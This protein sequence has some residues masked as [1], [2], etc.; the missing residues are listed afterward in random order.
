MTT[1]CTST[2][3]GLVGTVPRLDVGPASRRGV[4]RRPRAAPMLCVGTS[5]MREACARGVAR[6]PGALHQPRDALGRADLQHALDR[7]EVHAQVEARR[8][9]HG[10][11]ASPCFRPGLDPLAHRHGPSEP[12]CSAMRPA[13]SGR[14]SR[15]AWYQSSA[16]ERVFVNASRLR[17]DAI[18]SHD[19]RQHRQAQV[20]G[21]REALR[22]R[23]GSACR[24]TSGLWHVRPACGRPG[25]PAR[26][27][28]PR[29]CPAWPTGP[30]RA[31]PGSRR[32]QPR[33]RELHLHAALVADQFVPL[34][35]HH[36]P[37]RGRQAFARVVARSAAGS[38]FRAW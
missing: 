13:Q 5:V 33:Q 18:S 2:S 12:W 1:C 25:R 35:H 27:G 4:R 9:D 10:A 22:R 11:S 29:G 38:G 7:R 6:A 3:K 8:G 31:A 32:A 16:C 34:V 20:P 23:P 14:A 15:S 36:H 17:L 19:G 21:P 26:R 28:P 37:R 24:S 30:T